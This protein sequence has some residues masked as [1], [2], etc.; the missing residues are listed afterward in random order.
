MIFFN[1]RQ[2]SK[3]IIPFTKFYFLK[4]MENKKNMKWTYSNIFYHFQFWIWKTEVSRNSVYEVNVIWLMKLI[5]SIADHNWIMD[6]YHRQRDRMESRRYSNLMDLPGVNINTTS[7]ANQWVDE[8]FSIQERRF[9]NDFRPFFLLCQI[10]GM[11]PN[12]LNWKL[13]FSW[14]YWATY[15]CLLNLIMMFILLIFYCSQVNWK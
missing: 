11:F 12:K 13:S 8:E 3:P 4:K 10:S 1:Q 5:G 15:F 14:G 7:K 9:F 6:G 2:T